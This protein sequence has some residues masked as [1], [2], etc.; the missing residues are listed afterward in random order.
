MNEIQLYQAARHMRFMGSFA[1]AIGEAYFVGDCHNRTSLVQAFK[2]LFERALEL[3]NTTT[4]E[5]D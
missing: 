2:R 4:T 5:E 3:T 1:F